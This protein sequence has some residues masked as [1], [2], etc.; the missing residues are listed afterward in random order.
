MP[1]A[2]AVPMPVCTGPLP[3]PDPP[4]APGS[5]WT[6][7]PSVDVPPVRRPHRGPQGVHGP[8]RADGHWHRKHAHEHPRRSASRVRTKRRCSGRREDVPPTRRNPV[9]RWCATA[10]LTALSTARQRPPTACGTTGRPPA[11]RLSGAP[12]RSVIVAGGSWPVGTVPGRRSS[13]VLGYAC[14]SLWALLAADPAGTACPGRVP[15][16]GAVRSDQPRGSR[17]AAHAVLGNPHAPAL[18]RV[19]TTVLP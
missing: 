13:A 4:A 7:G 18:R 6:E 8:S 17:H 12:G 5:C 19:R 10:T 16:S 15:S 2:P 14:P 3:S 1:S 9:L 11:R